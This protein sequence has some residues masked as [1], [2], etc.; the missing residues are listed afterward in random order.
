MWLKVQQRQ[1]GA[2]FGMLGGN[3]RPVRVIALADRPRRRPHRFPISRTGSRRHNLHEAAN[4][5]LVF[6]IAVGMS[7][8]LHAPS[9]REYGRPIRSARFS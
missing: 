4:D 6:Q 3:S 9:P 5:C 8:P 1:L 2:R 7:G